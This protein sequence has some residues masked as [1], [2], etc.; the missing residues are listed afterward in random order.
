MHG[1]FSPFVATKIC[2]PASP[3]FET[4]ATLC[5]YEVRYSQEHSGIRTDQGMGMPTTGEPRGVGT[6]EGSEERYFALLDAAADAIIAVDEAQRITLFNQGAEAIFGWRA[7]EMLGQPLDRLIPERFRDANR[8]YLQELLA[9]PGQVRQIAQRQTLWGLRRD[10]SEFPAAASTSKVT[11]AG[12]TVLM[13]ILRDMTDSADATAAIS[14]LNQELSQRAAELGLA[15]EQLTRLSAMQQA[16]LD[17]AGYAIVSVD[18]DGHVVTFNPAAERLVGYRAAEAVGQQ[19]GVLW[20]D[21]A[22]IIDRAEALTRELGV[23]VTP[24]FSV[25]SI[26]A[27]GNRRDEREW[28][29]V[30]KDGT[31]VPVLLSMTALRDAQ[32][33]IT[34][35]LGIAADIT[36]RKRSEDAIR[37]LNRDLAHH[38][39]E[40][41]A[42]N[43][44]LEAFSYSVSHDLRAP[45]RSIDGFSQV[46]LEDY[47]EQLDPSGRDYLGRVRAASQ[48]MAQLIDDILALSRLTRGSLCHEA[49]DLSALAHAA[50]DELRRGQPERDVELVIE[51]G[52]FAQGDPRLLRVLLD[53]LV[54]NAWKYTSRHPR[55]KIEFGCDSQTAE[56]LVCFVRD[57]GAGFDPAY[58]DKLFGAFQR[59][60]STTEF[61]GNGIGLVTAQRIVHRHGGEIWAEGAVECG[62]TFHFSLPAAP[63]AGD[64]SGPG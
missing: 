26:L 11:I 5:H 8:Q 18:R 42:V 15:N 41:E 59:L 12:E 63:P 20:H 29:I 3:A 51:D 43:R 13:V 40:L 60:H 54:G 52:I 49:V 9:D 6:T 57:D 61:P 14:A 1:S 2:P 53:N 58:A 30:R 10:G 23:V 34:G 45:L 35:Y 38:S 33:S 28:T 16:I 27:D 36:E 24:D 47:A 46:L 25:F 48:R 31:R 62:A 4:P 50:V 55:A 37:V 56:Q 7:A 22:E 39:A 44:E 17:F 32:G 19:P 64:I 21:A